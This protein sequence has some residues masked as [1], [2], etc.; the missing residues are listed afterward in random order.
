[1]TEDEFW[2]RLEYRVSQELA[3]SENPQLRYLWVD[4]FLPRA[5]EHRDDGNW[6]VGTAW[7]ADDSRSQATWAFGLFLGVATREAADWARL[8]PRGTQWDG[9]RSTR[10]AVIWSYS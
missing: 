9:C 5:V 8:L 10:C 3:S 2:P 7:V 6:V 1:V 4:G